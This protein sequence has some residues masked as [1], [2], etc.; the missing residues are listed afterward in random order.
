MEWVLMAMIGWRHVISPILAT[1]Q[2]LTLWIRLDF[3]ENTPLSY[4]DRRR[5]GL[6]LSPKTGSM[7]FDWHGPETAT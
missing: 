4:I 6:Y 5:F 1:P 7:I 3:L 2:A